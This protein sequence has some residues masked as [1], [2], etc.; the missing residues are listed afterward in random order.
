MSC[1]PGGARNRH[2]KNTSSS[3]LPGAELSARLGLGKKVLVDV[4]EALR[5]PL[6]A[7][8]ARDTVYALAAPGAKQVAALVDRAIAPDTPL[9]VRDPSELCA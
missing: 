9:S 5:P 8:A 2:G 1:L 7:P 3:R 4:P 6:L